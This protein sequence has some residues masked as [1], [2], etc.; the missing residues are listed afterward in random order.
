MILRFHNTLK[1][2]LTT[3]M[4]LLKVKTRLRINILVKIPR[5]PIFTKLTL[6]QKI[7]K[8]RISVMFLKNLQE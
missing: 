3:N 1:L 6:T 2:I 7:I 4:L 5:K 8:N